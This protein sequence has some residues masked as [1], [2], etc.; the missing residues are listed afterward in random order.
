[1]FIEL[2]LLPVHVHVVHLVQVSTNEKLTFRFQ[3]APIEESHE[4][5]KA[6][7]AD[8]AEDSQSPPRALL[9]ALSPRVLLAS[10]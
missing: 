10:F 6:T 1:M 2:F 3:S 5:A 4:I 8:S 7:V 9:L